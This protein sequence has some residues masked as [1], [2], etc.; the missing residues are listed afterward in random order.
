[1][2]TGQRLPSSM[3]CI[4]RTSPLY[5]FFGV[6]SVFA[7]VAVLRCLLCRADNGPNYLTAMSNAGTE[8]NKM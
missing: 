7:F 4:D 8:T 6:G 5:P 1:M 2:L 3:Q